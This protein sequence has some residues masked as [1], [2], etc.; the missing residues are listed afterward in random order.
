MSWVLKLI[1]LYLC[2]GETF[3]SVSLALPFVVMD[4][5]CYFYVS[6]WIKKNAVTCRQ[7]TSTAAWSRTT[8]T[9]MTFNDTSVELNM[10]FFALCIF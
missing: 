7:F 6:T 8:D 9:R 5:F 10:R 4:L 2:D 1:S 3:S